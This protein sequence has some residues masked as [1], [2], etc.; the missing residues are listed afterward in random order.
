MS[1]TKFALATAIFI[2]LPL[3]ASA[4]S[5]ERYN[6]WAKEKVRY[7]S[8]RVRADPHN[9]QLR[10]LL[11][12]AL[13]EDGH[14]YEAETQLERALELQANFAEAHFN[15]AQTL[16]KLKRTKEAISWGKISDL[17]QHVTINAEA[18]VVLP[19]LVRSLI[20]E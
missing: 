9:A 4:E 15:L 12:N 11:G 3:A 17:A 14:N 8:D 18:S 10:V 20:H 7:L 16:R 6:M 19:L 13:Y 2:V 1:S 5:K